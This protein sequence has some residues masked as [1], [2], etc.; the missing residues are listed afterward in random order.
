MQNTVNLASIAEMQGFERKPL[1]DQHFL[2]AGRLPESLI[3]DSCAFEALWQLHPQE[4]HEIK[5]HGRLVKTP[6]WQQAFGRDYQYAGRVNRGLPIPVSI[7]PL[8]GWGQSNIDGRLNG[9]LVNWYDGALGHYIGKH[10]D[11]ASN[12]VPGTPIVTISFGEE[13]VFRLR[14]WSPKKPANQ[15]IDFPTGNG[16]VFVMPWETN[17]AFTHEVPH[18][19]KKSGRRISMTLR[20][21]EDR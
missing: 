18:S 14:N 4:F 6:R 8:L 3:P 20:A 21:F 1:F 9:I 13:R 5:I 17:L 19:R 11:S 16:S 7:E 12:M 10:R 2:L 15:P